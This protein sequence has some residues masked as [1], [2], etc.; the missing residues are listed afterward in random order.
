RE[1]IQEFPVEIR[2]E[3]GKAIYDVQKGEKL[4][5][6]LTRSM[7]SIASGVEELRLKERSGIYRALFYARLPDRVLVFHA[8][9]KKTQ[10]TPMV[11]IEIGRKRLKELRN[12]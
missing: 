5:M 9:K 2:R 1:A 6:P 3:L 12:E 8:F 10:R 4:K 11:E 7:P